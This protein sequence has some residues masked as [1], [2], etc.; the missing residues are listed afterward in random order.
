ML[1]NEG[2][3][4]RIFNNLVKRSNFLAEKVISLSSLLYITE[5]QRTVK[6]NSPVNTK[7]GTYMVGNP[8]LPVENISG[9]GWISNY[10]LSFLSAIF[11]R[12]VW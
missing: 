5:Q 4:E 11:C 1:N 9:P 8:F 10:T 12:A 2:I 7:S 3:D 6:S